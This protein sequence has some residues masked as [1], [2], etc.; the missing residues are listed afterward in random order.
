VEPEY[1]IITLHGYD[2][3]RDMQTIELGSTITGWNVSG[4]WLTVYH[5]DGD[6]RAMHLD[7]FSI[8]VVRITQR[9]QNDNAG[10]V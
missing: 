5:A 9:L 3:N 6:K 4:D 1:L 7:D 8:R 2:A 10:A